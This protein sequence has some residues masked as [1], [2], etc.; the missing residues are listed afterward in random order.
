MTISVTSLV[1]TI[2]DVTYISD[3]SVITKSVMTTSVMTKSVM[4]ISVMTKP[5][6]I[7]TVITIS[8]MIKSGASAK[9]VGKRGRFSLERE[10][11]LLR[12]E[13]LK[14]GQSVVKNWSKS[15]HV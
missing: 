2:S 13:S 5:V 15:G 14:T 10:G 6:M 8:V 1:V 3:K 11:P 9:S 7:R 12:A 4:T